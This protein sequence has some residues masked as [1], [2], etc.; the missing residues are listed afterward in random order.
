METPSP[1]SNNCLSLCNNN[2]FSTNYERLTINTVDGVAKGNV[3]NLT[4]HPGQAVKIITED[5]G[6]H[7]IIKDAK[8]VGSSKKTIKASKSCTDFYEEKNGTLKSSKSNANLKD[9][10]NCDENLVK[11]IFTK[12]GI[13]VISDV[14][15]IV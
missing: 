12:H 7:K 13:Q 2:I 9:C 6:E 8:E 11:F 5:T 1:I 4:K 10:K 14:E 15:T 3:I